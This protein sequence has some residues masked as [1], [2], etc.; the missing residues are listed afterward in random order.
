M[1]ADL[2]NI[3]LQ[4][5]DWDPKQLHSEF[6]SITNPT[7]NLVDDATAFAT[8][9][10]L[11]Y[12]WEMSDYGITEAYIDDIFTVFPL[13]SENHWERGRNAALLAIDTMGRPTHDEDHLPRDPIIALKKLKAEGTPSEVMVVL[14]WQID[15]RRLRIQLPNEKAT[16]WEEELNRLIA[17]G[18]K[19]YQIK[20]KRLESIQ[21]RNIHVASVVPG[22][23]HFQSR[24]YA[25]IDR[26]RNDKN[27]VTRLH[28]EERNDLR[29]VR[30]LVRVAKRGISLNNVVRRMPDHI[31]RSD[32]FEGGIGGYNLASGRAWRYQIQPEDRHQKSQNFLE[33]LACMTQLIC[34][35]DERKWKQGDCILSVGDNTSALGWIHKSNFRPEEDK[36]QTTHLALARHITTLLAEIHVTQSGCWL[37]GKDNG[38]ADTLSR[39]HDQTNAELTNIIVKSFPEQVPNG[40]RIRALTPEVTSWV[41]YWVQHTHA[42]KESPPEPLQRVKCGGNGGSSS[43]TT[44]NLA[45]MCISDNLHPTN[46]TCSSELSHTRSAKSKRHTSHWRGTSRRYWRRST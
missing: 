43:Y 13:L 20:L 10:E 34:I 28:A 35:L 32:A 16:R 8:A 44:V 21:G 40:F 31:G 29:L 5:K 23:M 12:E 22:A 46:A 4:H 24:I 27:R 30:Q 14:G 26:A 17:D 38:V 9:R 41:R 39:Q 42:T 3:L 15:T 11:L 25:A 33:Y 7:P 6:I 2:A 36:E 1:I 37:P 45:T 19:G 18:D